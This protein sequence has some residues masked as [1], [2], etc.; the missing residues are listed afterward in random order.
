MTS[1]P[2][3]DGES[4]PPDQPLAADS[5]EVAGRPVLRRIEAIAAGYAIFAGIAFAIAD[6]WRRGIV[7]TAAGGVS[8]VALRSL[9]GVVRRLR[10]VSGEPASSLGWRYPLRLFLLVGLVLLLRLGWHDGLAVVL[11]LLAVPLGLL[12]E[13]GFQL[14]SLPHPNRGR[15]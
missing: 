13:A 15:K 6:D 11:G 10:A 3:T 12:V 1:W 8:I 5:G 4:P 9:E 14:L 7:L 2:G